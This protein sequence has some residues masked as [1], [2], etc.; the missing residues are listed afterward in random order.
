MTML[1]SK[2]LKNM[3]F[4]LS[5]RNPPVVQVKLVL[6][7]LDCLSGLRWWWLVFPLDLTLGSVAIAFTNDPRSY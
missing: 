2:F 7:H 3:G 1:V 6:G 4:Y 5:I